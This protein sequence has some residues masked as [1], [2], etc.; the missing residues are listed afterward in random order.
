[1]TPSVDPLYSS[2]LFFSVFFQKPHHH[3][4]SI[5]EPAVNFNCGEQLQTAQRQILPHFEEICKSHGWFAN[6]P[7]AEKLAQLPMNIV[8]TE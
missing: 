1:M 2:L 4:V 7:E 6:N 8:Y 3:Y 5:C